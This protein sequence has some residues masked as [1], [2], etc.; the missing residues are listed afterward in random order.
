MA[1]CIGIGQL[2]VDPA[3]ASAKEVHTKASP[4]VEDGKY[5]R[6]ATEHGEDDH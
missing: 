2:E 3:F 1:E 4:L 6:V 5:D